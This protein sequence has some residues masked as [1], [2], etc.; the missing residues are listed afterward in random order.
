MFSEIDRPVQKK[1]LSERGWAPYPACMNFL[2]RLETRLS[3]HF[4]L[5]HP[6]YTKW[7]E[8]GLEREQLGAYARQYFHTWMPFRAI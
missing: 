2:K 1:R 6:F 4:L 5:R 7:T 8:G 3:D